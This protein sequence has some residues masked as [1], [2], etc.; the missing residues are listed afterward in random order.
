MIPVLIM[1]MI[2]NFVIFFVS[3]HMSRVK[4]ES[5]FYILMRRLQHTAGLPHSLKLVEVLEVE[6]GRAARALDP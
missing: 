5:L 6:R 4:A 1:R 2:S 3:W